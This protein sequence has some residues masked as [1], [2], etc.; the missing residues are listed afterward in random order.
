MRQLSKA[1]ASMTVPRPVLNQGFKAQIASNPTPVFQ[2]TLRRRAPSMVLTL[3]LAVFVSGAALAASA[4]PSRPAPVRSVARAAAAAGTDFDYLVILL[5]ENHNICDILTSCSGSA[6]YMSNLANAWG[7]AQDDH[8]CNVNPSLPNY[9]CL[10][11]GTDFGCNGYDG[12]PNSNACT[13]A[14]WT[15]PNIVDRLAPAGLTWKAYMEDMPSNCYGGNSGNYAVRHNPF[16]YYNDIVSNSMRCNQVVPAGTADS[17]LINDLGSTSTAS[18]YMWLTPNT[19]NDMH[20]CSIGTGDAYLADLVQRIL[21]SPVFTNQRAAL[22]ITFDEGYGQPVY[23]VWAGRV[24]KPTYSSSVA[25]NHTSLLATIESNWNLA[26]LT[27]ND[28]GAS[29]M[30]EFFQAPPLSDSVPPTISID[31]PTNHTNVS[32]ALTVSGTAFD[33]IAIRQVEVRA[34]GGPWMS[35]SGTTSWS[36]SLSLALGNHT[37]DARVTD[38]AGNQKTVG[39]SVTAQPGGPPAGI[40]LQAFLPEIA[41]AVIVAAIVVALLLRRRRKKTT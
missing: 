41:V 7:L 33:N 24:V 21:S 2:G 39:I 23:T 5:M 38:F 8:Y 37:I 11:G 1:V 22:Y 14:A 13:N 32:A 3:L 36:G 27:S 19:C 29:P 25:Y 40:D 9:L 12:G 18:N 17:A 20:D 34:D 16:V 30:T 28:G 35:A 31:S 15:A 6:V 26:P 10:T 4:Q